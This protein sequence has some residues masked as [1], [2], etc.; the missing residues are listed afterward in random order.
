MLGSEYICTR[1]LLVL[2]VSDIK[3]ACGQYIMTNHQISLFEIYILIYT[4]GVVGGCATTCI[5]ATCI[6]L[7]SVLSIMLCPH[8]T[9]W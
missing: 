1:H 7:V 3:R 4:D 9:T 8:K 2:G 6:G 5:T